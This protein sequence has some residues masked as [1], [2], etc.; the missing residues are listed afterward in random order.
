MMTIAET[1]EK[2]PK[3]I[4]VV[5]DNEDNRDIVVLRLKAMG[6]YEILEASN[7]RE[8]LK[9]AARS[10]PDLIFMDLKMPVM[11]GW[12]ATKA[13][14]ETEWGKKLPIIAL[15]AHTSDEDREKAFQVGCNDLVAK[16]VLDYRA[17]Q[18][19]LQQLLA[20]TRYPFGT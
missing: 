17:I 5:E 15:T 7:G 3:K 4:L 13:L 11:D 18:K 12:E 9:I 14:R 1:G 16:P 8:A 20:D 19:K 10:K 6:H 2:C